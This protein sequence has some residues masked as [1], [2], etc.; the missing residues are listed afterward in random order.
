M[1]TNLKN[2]PIY[3]LGSSGHEKS[4]VFNTEGQNRY[5]VKCSILVDND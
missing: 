5:C 2:K 1:P 3:I 4:M